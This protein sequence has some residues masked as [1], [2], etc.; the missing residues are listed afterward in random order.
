MQI[1][2]DGRG[3]EPAWLHSVVVAVTLSEELVAAMARRLREG[4]LRYSTRQLYYAVCAELES[5]VPTRGDAQAG[6]GALL[7]VTGVVAGIY[8]SI[9]VGLAVPFGLL[10][11]AMGL[12][13]R[14]AERNRPTTRP[15]ALGYDEFLAELA[16]LPARTTVLGGAIDTVAPAGSPAPVAGGSLVVCDGRES[17]LMLAANLGE[18]GVTVVDE[19]SA[20]AHLTTAARVL[21]VHDADAR[22]CALPLRLRAA[23]AG[24]VID[25]GL[26]PGQI[27]GRRLQVIEGAPLLLS[28]DVAALLS[29]DE[30]VWLAAGRR[31]ELAIVTPRELVDAVLAA[32]ADGAGVSQ[33][34]GFPAGIVVSQ[35]VPIAATV[36]TASP[37]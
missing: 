37:V 5:P 25:L 23:G 17:A 2:G 19:A 6:L 15:L 7:M 12:Q 26:R 9:Y 22:G 8:V 20:A 30:I 32:I 36:A 34:P 29:P 31:A 28:A 3:G 11:T 21:S 1:S 14:R 16:T 35:V 18:R 10:I 33:P 4:D 27:T 24:E 13:R